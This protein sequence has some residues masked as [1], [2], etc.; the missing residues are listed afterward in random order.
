MVFVFW[1]AIAVIVYSYF[2]YPAFLWIWSHLHRQPAQFGPYPASISIVMVVRNEAAVLQRKLR[3]LLSID[4]PADKTEIIVVS[5]GS[6]D[7][8]NSIL[9]EFGGAPQLRSVI[10]D[11]PLGKAVGLNDAMEAARAEIVVFT[12]ARQYIEL[13][14]VRL[15][16]EN[17]ADPDVGCA[18]GELM[19]GDPAA[20][21]NT[22]GLGRYWKFEKKIREM[23]S[24]SGS[25]IGATGALYAARRSLLVRLPPETI[26]DD[27]YIPMHILRQGKRVIFDSRARAWDVPHQ[28]HQREFARKVRTLSGIYQLLQLAPWLLGPSN[29]GWFRF[30]SHKVSRLLVPLALV[31]VLLSSAVL[32]SAIYRIALILQLVF[33]GLGLWTL[34]RERHI[35]SSRI[36]EVASSI[37]LL[38]T[39]A[40]VALVN[41]LFGRKAAW[42]R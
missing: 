3:N 42:V 11:R 17:F 16:V 13:S 4:Y 29:P 25:V 21:E 39:A 31:A 38:N 33:Y 40:L 36:A 12:D 28:G 9:A 15:L 2:A 23:E 32:P 1:G 7:N 5:D 24:A 10:R 41:V 30:L 26:V 20:G 22:R 34:A 8:S 6:T 14:A 19:L 27:V 18:G 37:L 35:V